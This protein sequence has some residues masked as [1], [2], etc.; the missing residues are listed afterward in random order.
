MRCEISQDNGGLLVYARLIPNRCGLLS[1]HSWRRELQEA[2]GQ[3]QGRVRSID[4]WSSSPP[5]TFWYSLLLTFCSLHARLVLLSYSDWTFDSAREAR[6]ANM[7]STTS[8]FIDFRDVAHSSLA[9]LSSDS[10]SLAISLRSSSR[11]SLHSL[12]HAS[13]PIPRSVHRPMSYRCTHPSGTADLLSHDT[14]RH[15]SRYCL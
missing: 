12:P 5:H 8:Q 3:G 1:P 11:S 10:L 14:T 9:N 7:F 15:T 4:R 2:I 13:Q 6:A